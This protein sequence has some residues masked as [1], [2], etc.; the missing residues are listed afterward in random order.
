MEVR[1]LFD[2]YLKKQILKL[3]QSVKKELHNKLDL[4]ESNPHKYGKILSGTKGK[5]R[6]IKLSGYRMYFTLIQNNYIIIVCFELENKTSNKKQKRTIKKI[7]NNIERR[8][9]IALYPKIFSCK[10]F[11]FNNLVKGFIELF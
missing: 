8:I 11:A 5:L 4:L 7:F 2:P 10:I 3:D 6:E 1:T 9:R